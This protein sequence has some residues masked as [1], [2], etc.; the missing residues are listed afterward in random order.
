MHLGLF[1]AI[2]FELSHLLGL[3]NN[4]FGLFRELLIFFLGKS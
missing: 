2:F 3:I 4:F 1:R